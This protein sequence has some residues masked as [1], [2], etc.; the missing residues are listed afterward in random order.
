MKSIVLICFFTAS[1]LSAQLSTF[2]NRDLYEMGKVWG[3]MKYY[4]PAISQG[5]TD[6]DGVLLE[7]FRSGPKEGVNGLVKNWLSKADQ[8]KFDKVAGKD[9]KCDSITLR[10]FDV[11][12]IDKLKI[13]PENK[14]RL[15]KLVNQPADVGSFYSNTAKSSIYFSSANEKVHGTFSKEVKMLDLFRIW[16]AIEYFYPYKYLLDH[17]WDDILKKYIPLFKKINNE[18]DYESAVM[19]LAAELQDTHAGIEETYQYDV[20]GKLSSPFTFQMVENA[21]LITGIKDEA[22]M[23]KANLE[24]GDLITKIN[25]KPILKN[26][27]EKSKYFAFSNP[28]VELREAYSYLFSGDEETIVVEGIHKN[29]EKFRTAVERTKRIFYEEWDKD[30]IPDLHLVYKGKNYNYLT[31]NEKESRLNPSFP[32]D[33]KVYFEFASLKGAEIPSLM[34][35][36]KHTKGMV[37]DLR[38]YND[39]ASLLKVFDYLLTNPVV[40]GIKTQPNFSQP[41]KF[42]FVDN[43]VNKEYKF[44]GKDNPDPYKGLVVVIINEHTQSAEEMWAMVFKKIPNVIFVGS[45]TAGADGNKTSIKLT[46]GHKIIFSGLGIYYPDGGETQRIGIKPD[47]VVRPTVESTRN[48][49]DLLLLRALELID[50][51]K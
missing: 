38:G 51:K 8:Q 3:L 22:K 18:K 41:G 23:K 32:I 12:W 28:S 19:Q 47:V 29:G 50:Q 48:K 45:Q 40:Y 39:N 10:N 17:N 21:V 30:G 14:I 25:G 24:V 11:S 2:S 44:A 37:F 4:H 42:C 46:D 43:I 1:A 33:D 26:I 16:N 35:Q 34:E 36:Y 49:E 31:Y 15:T 5:K 20:A 13:S 9:N 7:S 27:K 6:W